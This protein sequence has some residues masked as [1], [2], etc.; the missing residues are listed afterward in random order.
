MEERWSPLAAACD[1]RTFC[2]L[3][4]PCL[5]G[6]RRKW[7]ELTLTATGGDNGAVTH[8]EVVARV[9]RERDD[10]TIAQLSAGLAAAST[11]G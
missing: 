4:C 1:A 8:S 6:L 2:R 11:V 10:V 5:A 7:A 3:D 9:R